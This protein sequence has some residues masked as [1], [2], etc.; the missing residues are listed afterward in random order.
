[1]LL[2]KNIINFKNMSVVH[3]V[4]PH[5]G[6]KSIYSLN[7][8]KPMTKKKAI[9]ELYNYI[10]MIE[11]YKNF[12]DDLILSICIK[13]VSKLKDKHLDSIIEWYYLYFGICV[14]QC[15]NLIDQHIINSR[16]I[17]RQFIT[18]HIWDTKYDIGRKMFDFRCDQDCLY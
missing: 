7:I 3:G 6:K 12:S 17:V 13:Y 9:M 8:G 18:K 15:R 2:I 14:K 1:M 4:L 10:K 11:V 16:I 5:N